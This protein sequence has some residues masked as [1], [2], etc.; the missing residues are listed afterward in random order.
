MNRMSLLASAVTAALA[1][2]SASATAATVYD[3]DGTTLDI[4]GRVQAVGYSR[5]HGYV[6]HKNT[7]VS[8]GRLGIS[9]RSKVNDSVSVLAFQ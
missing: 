4:F 9:A 2:S 1:L 7:L 3:H 5:H 8:S 6:E